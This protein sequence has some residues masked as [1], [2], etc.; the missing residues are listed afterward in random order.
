MLEAIVWNHFDRFIRSDMRA[1]YAVNWNIS[2]NTYVRVEYQNGV[3]IERFRKCSP[4]NN[5]PSLGETKVVGSG[6]RIW[7]DGIRQEQYEKF[8]SRNT[9]K[10]LE[11]SLLNITFP[12]FTKSVVLGDNIL[13]SFVGSESKERR[14]IFEGL[15]GLNQFDQFLDFTRKQKRQL[16]NYLNLLKFHSEN[17]LQQRRA[18]QKKISEYEDKLRSSLQEQAVISQFSTT[19]TAPTS[20]SSLPPPPP[21]PLGRHCRIGPTLSENLSVFLKGSQSMSLFKRM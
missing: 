7:K 4:K 6:V 18:I 11:N 3:A 14:E 8:D 13:Q 10:I 9:Q 21:P 20:S 16:S 1:E 19:T 12:I 17:I 5:L 15:I 2:Q